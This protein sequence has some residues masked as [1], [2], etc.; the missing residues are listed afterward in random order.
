MNWIDNLQERLN[1]LPELLKGIAEISKESSK[2]AATFFN[3]F[4]GLLHHFKLPPRGDKQDAELRTKL[5][6]TDEDDESFVA[7]YIGKLF[8]YTASAIRNKACPGLSVEDCEFLQLYN[9]PDTWSPSASI[10]LNL[11][12][13]KVCAAKF[14]ASGAFTEEKRFVPALI[15]SADVNSRLSEIGE[16]ILKRAL[17]AVSKED[18]ELVSTLFQLY[19]GSPTKHILPAST[20]LQTKVLSI[21]CTSQIATD[22]TS[23]IL[24]IVKGSLGADR[25][26]ATA[27]LKGL[28][29]AK[30]RTQVFNFVTW[31]ARIG[32]QARIAVIATDIVSSL[33]DYISEQGWPTIVDELKN[34]A[35]EIQLRAYGYESIGLLAKASPEDLIYDQKLDLLRWFFQSLGGDASS[36]DVSLSIEQSMSSILGALSGSRDRASKALT[37]LLSHYAS[38]T[39][40]QEDATGIT[41]HRNTRYMAVRFSNRCLPFSDVNGR[42]I[43]LLALSAGD[44]ERREVIEEGRRG[45][46]PYW[47]RILNPSDGPGGNNTKEESLYDFPDFKLLVEELFV[48]EN[49]PLSSS[50]A[51]GD[52]VVFC[53][54][55]LLH[56]ALASS[57]K[58]PIIDADW[59]RNI[60]ALIRNDEH[61]RE[62]VKIFLQNSIDTKTD[63]NALIRLS[64][65]AF[66]DY[67]RPSSGFRPLSG[68]A[69]IELFQLGPV[70]LLDDPNILPRAS[71]LKGT[72]FSTFQSARILSARILGLLASRRQFWTAPN[73]VLVKG[74]LK[75][76]EAW[77]RAV[78]SEVH[79][80]HGCMVT[81]A[82]VLSRS[83]CTGAYDVSGMRQVFIKLVLSILENSREKELTHAA[84]ISISQMSL[85][86]TLSQEEV[87]ESYPMD[88]FLSK[89]EESAAKGDENAITCAGHFAMRC[90]EESEDS[91]PLRNLLS[92]LYGLNVVRQ[93][94]VQFSVGSALSCATVGWDSKALIGDFDVAGPPP[95]VATRSELLQETVDKILN[96]CKT[97]KPALRQASVIWLLCIVQYCGHRNEIQT[98]LRQC[99]VAFKGFLSD[100]ESVNQEVASRGLSLI[101]DKGDRELKDDLVRDLVTSFTSTKSN[102]SGSV[103]AETELFEPGALPTGEGQSVTTYKDIISLASEVGDPSLV[104]RFMSLA[105]NSAIW[106]SRS[107]FGRFGLSRVLSDA[108]VDGYLADNPK[109]YSSLFRYRF[110]PNS[111]V[112]LSMNEIW[113]SLVKD[114][115]ATI[116]QHFDRILQD[117]F[118]SILNKE[119]RTR[120]A[121]CAA[122]AD[123]LQGRPLPMYE[124]YLTQIWELTFKVCDDIKGSVR[125][126]AM[127]L[128]RTLTGILIRS[129]EAGETSAITANAM[130]KQV[131]PFLLGPSG[132]ECAAQDVQAFSLIT[133][134]DIIK[135]ASA[136]I[137]RPFI[138]D[139]IGRLISLL[140]SI[141]PG[142]INYVYLNAEKYGMTE[143]QIDDARLSS[144]KMSPMMEAIERCLDMLDE[145]IMSEVEGSLINASKTV[146]GLPSRVGLCRVMVSLAT[147]H[148]NLFMPYAGTFLKL[149]RRQVMDRNDTIS[150]S[151]AAACGYLSRLASD[152]EILALVEH[153]RKIYFESEDD[154]HRT[155]AGEILLAIAKHATDRF[156]SLASSCLPFAYFGLHD[157]SEAARDLFKAAWEENAGGSR[158]V[159]LY[160]REIID[161]S[162][163]Q[164]ESHRW[165]IKHTA[166]FTIADTVKA[167]SEIAD[168]D[169]M[170][171]WPALEKAI[172]GKTWNGKEK[173]LEAFVQFWKRSQLGKSNIKIR[174]SMEKI[175]VR[176]AKRHNATY[177]VHSLKGLSDI[178][179]SLSTIHQNGEK[180]NVDWFDI[181]LPIVEPILKEH[182]EGSETDSKEDKMDIDA[183]TEGGLS[184]KDLVETTVG[185]S[186]RALIESASLI[187]D[188]SMVKFTSNISQILLKIN[189][190]LSNSTLSSRN[191][192][193][194][195]AILDASTHLFATMSGLI[196]A[197]DKDLDQVLS[198]FSS[199][200]LFD[201]RYSDLN[202]GLRQQI[203]ATAS[204]LGSLASVNESSKLRQ[205]L[206]DGI[207]RVKQGER[208]QTVLSAWIKIE[209]TITGG[210][211]STT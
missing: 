131:L 29:A 178:L 168:T 8:L 115:K 204:C 26:S 170:V 108:S 200:I 51:F 47:Y 161:L 99:Q 126:A 4:L 117:L 125:T 202:E 9:K 155:I 174:E 183:K 96:D 98:R 195:S 164:L 95:K 79:H 27:G 189:K 179:E 58:S 149:L 17:P 209:E 152:V 14:L 110:D 145:S 45:L 159:L 6:L 103:S 28:A 5:M 71:E 203:T 82:Y 11:I 61:A 75:A 15:A 38:L 18:A 55:V 106:S 31:I 88:L 166:A 192:I 188:F 194:L 97:T 175:I 124:Q 24:E 73:I 112:R 128:A 101:Y 129:L 198:D 207:V 140:T 20:A 201:A 43:A 156:A 21:L 144:V 114:S 7:E 30:L 10:G 34:N 85:Y 44:T 191:N 13:T 62:G 123:L 150:T 130:L 68:K 173:V 67:V 158:A 41:I 70:S 138:P 1:L 148:R 48:T 169:A 197:F 119:W 91:T 89:I 3:L 180:T 78:G 187:S 64:R 186:L 23:E 176:E 147:R 199:A 135:K 116:D 141:E 72:I 19:L 2:H 205:T 121:S 60:E 25:I 12:E 83:N 139:L 182:L 162:V 190:A 63:S 56:K 81:I 53:W 52:A 39:P 127:A 22:R 133:L 163:A 134:M 50:R 87:E 69:I 137:L 76:I 167:G 210:I 146:I 59:Q 143:Q 92:K 80:V 35:S 151:A 65:A 94:E 49:N 46:D 111:N 157:T 177:R 102:L 57:E 113:T 142:V 37:D 84:F 211:Q 185:N 193:I 36:K 118:K 40:G 33:R 107:A 120:Q 93:A 32:S 16:D 86:N 184:S 165:V 105:S 196:S 206:V 172:G 153:A 132:L 42:L 136:K 181:V 122:I 208:S 104:Y 171:I 54:T 90:R 160:L 77:E 66:E 100:K 154:R 109:L 74:L